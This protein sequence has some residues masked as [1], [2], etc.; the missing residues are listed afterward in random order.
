MGGSVDGYGSFTNDYTA[1]LTNLFGDTVKN[2]AV[3]DLNGLSNL[4]VDQLRAGKLHLTLSFVTRT[5]SAIERTLHVYVGQETS[6]LSEQIVHPSSSNANNVWKHLTET[7]FTEVASIAVRKGVA[8]F[9]S[10]ENQ[11]AT[12]TIDITSQMLSAYDRGIT[13]F[14]IWF[15][16]T[17]A[18]TDESL[19]ITN[20]SV[21][22]SGLSPLPAFARVPYQSV[23]SSGAFSPFAE[24]EVTIPVPAQFVQSNDDDDGNSVPIPIIPA[25]ATATP[26][27]DS[28]VLLA[29]PQY[30]LV[31]QTNAAAGALSGPGLTATPLYV[32]NGQ[33]A[34][35]VSGTA[36]EVQTKLRAATFTPS[37]GVSGT[38]A[39]TTFEL[40]EFD[41]PMNAVAGV[42]LLLQGAT[43]AYLGRADT[44]G[45][46]ALGTTVFVRSGGTTTGESIGAG[47]DTD[48]VLR[49]SRQI[50]GQGGLARA[51][52]VAGT[53]LT[54]RSGGVSDGAVVTGFVDPTAIYNGQEVIEDGGKSRNADIQGHGLQVV[55]HGGL[56]DTP[57]IEV[58]GRAEIYG[59]IDG[60]IIYG[61][62]WVYAGGIATSVTVSRSGSLTVLQGGRIDD[63]VIGDGTVILSAG[64]IASGRITFGDGDGTLEI[65]AR[66]A[67][68]TSTFPVTIDGFAPGDTLDLAGLAYT[69]STVVTFTK[70][71]L[72]VSNG[73]ATELFNV[74]TPIQ[75]TLIAASDG[76][77]GTAITLAP[78]V[79][80]PPPVAPT[81]TGSGD[82]RVKGDAVAPFARVQVTDANPG[83]IDTVTIRL[84]DGGAGGVLSGPG[85]AL[86]SAGT[87][88]V[89]GTADSVTAKLRALTFT[90]S[91]QQPNTQ[92][93][94]TFTLVDSSSAG[95]TATSS[96]FSVTVDTPIVAPQ[97]TGGATLSVRSEA[98]STPFATAAVLDPNAG[99]L[100]TLTILLSDGGV[101]GVLSGAGLSG[102]KGAYTISG[103]AQQV[104]AALQALVFTPAAGAPGLALTTTFTL[105][106]KGSVGPSA[107]SAAFSVTNT[108]PVVAPTIAGG[109]GLVVT[110]EAPST[111]FATATL[112][113]PNYNSTDV[114]AIQLS[115]GGAGGVL[116]GTGLGGGSGGAYTLTGTAAN[117][118][119][120]LQRL[121][122][123]PAVGAPG[124][125]TTTS[126]TLTA[127]SSAG[128]TATSSTFS[129]RNVDPPRIV[130]TGAVANP[131]AVNDTIIDAT[132]AGPHTVIVGA[133]ARNT[134]AFGS[135]AG[136]VTG[137]GTGSIVRGGTGA[138]T[139]SGLGGSST[140]LLG[141]GNNTVNLAAAGAGNRIVAGNGANRIAAG[142]G[143]NE[144]VTVGNGA[145]VISAGGANDVVLAGNGNN[146][147]TMTGAAASV[148]TGSGNDVITL[149]GPG[150]ATILAGTGTN[151]IS[152]AGA[153]SRIVNQGGTD[154]LIDTGSANTIELPR[155]GLGLVT[156][157]ANALTNG[158]VFDLRVA[159][160]ATAWDHSNATLGAFLS[161]GMQ[162]NDATIAIDTDGPGGGAS[163]TVA[164]ITGAGPTSLAA[165]LPHTLT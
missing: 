15:A 164:V 58:G 9:S 131:G 26:L 81:I 161:T 24:L 53:V 22:T 23:I 102:N 134:I 46:V 32:R 111:P 11:N 18:A 56:S 65:D 6:E 162:G 10:D 38:A 104:T 109:S 44:D 41:G 88:S 63:L 99:S 129:V 64:A 66:V 1:G 142:N 14:L 135:G 101:G 121:V 61:D 73:S 112:T 165:L 78:I 103:T 105:K 152:F 155:A 148:T 133:G 3:F 154:L 55:M 31:I 16:N 67:P 128:T 157:G 82:A 119:Q 19:N 79:Q 93:K 90:P 12:Q 116:S 70:S 85:L 89:S 71:T 39:T 94:T 25:N 48:D 122:F 43:L 147:I 110:S 160:A 96:S 69:A 115:N 145:N 126:F 28:S 21:E 72:T 75:G 153:G 120:A 158:D 80:P 62:A 86:V 140:I 117:V 4:V 7:S 51:T 57:T 84:S 114:L 130:V 83:S 127:T 146:T 37:A 156:I 107:S 136:T 125:A 54:V 17:G 29:G 95:T 50:V 108:D 68:G 151:R 47:R 123:T 149:T 30:Y 138:V 13:N 100:D 139:V 8:P 60:A 49:G 33:S 74:R 97:I 144:Q 137:T 59:T 5:S 141:D 52:H 132:S 92:L 42:P 35:L 45:V 118:T 2:Y 20:L 159:M 36:A 91:P 40:R 143:G 150:Q 113:D 77:A 87:Y 76:Q 27:V 98:A 124:T 163:V 34:Y 106:V